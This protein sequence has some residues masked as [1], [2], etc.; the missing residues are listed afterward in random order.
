MSGTSKPR[1]R[2][3]RI[4][5][6]G[7]QKPR[8]I[9]WWHDANKVDVFARVGIA[10]TAAIAM[11]ILCQTWRPP[12]AYRL[13]AIPARDLISRVTFEMPNVEETKVLQNNRR[14][15]TLA[16]YRN[17]TE[18][19][20]QLQAALRDQLFLVLG[21]DAYD[22]LTEE[23]QIAFAQF[24]VGD[25]SDDASDA[26]KVRFSMLKSV[27][28]D[29]KELKTLQ[30]TLDIAMRKNFEKGV[31]QTL[32]HSSDQGSKDMIRVY[33]AGL[34]DDSK[35]VEVSDVRVAEASVELVSQLKEQFRTRFSG[36]ANQEEA[37]Q[38]VAQMIADWIISRLKDYETLQYDDEKSEQARQKAA[39]AVDPVMTPYRVG[40]SQL[41]EAGKP[42]R[43]KEL[44]LL[45][46]EW[47]ELVGKMG[48]TDNISRVVAYAGMIAALYLLCASY[49]FFVDDRT[50][51]LDRWKLAKLLTVVVR[52]IVGVAK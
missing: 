52:R 49:I 6:L 31:I 37:I 40:D 43:P 18:P 36:K 38:K 10:V 21:A 1:N 41:A 3:E 8:L 7:I 48:F 42:L 44:G 47:G 4:D 2:Q 32:T 11:L 5:S 50:L 9:Q 27:L 15:E 22:Q 35:P 46:K 14:R 28:A 45:E 25:E 24:Y 26:P 33:R 12:F 19:L 16:F 13:G 23:E 17:R 51:L 34:P 29:D 20:K 39:A 30:E